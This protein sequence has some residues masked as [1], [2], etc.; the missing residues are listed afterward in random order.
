ME[1]DAD[2]YALGICPKHGIFISATCWDCTA[3]LDYIEAEYYIVAKPCA[4]PVGTILDAPKAVAA[5]YKTA[6][7]LV[8]CRGDTLSMDAFPDLYAAVKGLYG[9]SARNRT[10]NLP[11]LR[12]KLLGV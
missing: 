11:D 3:K 1:W 2:L 6:T 12:G 4:M 9:M 5:P 7:C 10:F 8:P